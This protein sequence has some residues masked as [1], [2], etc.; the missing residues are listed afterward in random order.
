MTSLAR[1]PFGNR[2]AIFFSFVREHRAGDHVADGPNTRHV[3]AKMFVDFD[4]FA[5]IELPADFVETETIRIRTAS[6]GDQNFVGRKFEFLTISFSEQRDT[7]RFATK[8]GHLRS[9]FDLHALFGEKACEVA[10][11][12]VV[13]GR[14]DLGKK[15]NDGHIRTE[16]RPDGAE[17]EADCSAADDDEFFRHFGKRD[18]VIR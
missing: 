7:I 4:S 17:F 5:L 14:D 11:D 8:F 1:D 9:G 3:R 6:D 18:C 16:P 2:D 12:V 10:D 15:F 13:V